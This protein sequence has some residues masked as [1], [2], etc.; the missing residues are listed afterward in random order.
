MISCWLVV[1][2]GDV[3]QVFARSVN[4]DSQSKHSFSIQHF[5]LSLGYVVCIY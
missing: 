1:P 2:G 3:C 5:H 4:C